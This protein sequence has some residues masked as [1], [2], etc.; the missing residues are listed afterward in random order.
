MTVTLADFEIPLLNVP[1]LATL[2]LK[3]V[4]NIIGHFWIKPQSF[5]LLE[6]IDYAY[7]AHDKS[8]PTP[9]CDRVW[10]C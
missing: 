8:K 2:G 5:F 1:Y 7:Y 3:I 10:S 6:G 4:I 9:L